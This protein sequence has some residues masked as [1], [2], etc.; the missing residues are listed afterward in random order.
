MCRT[1]K[2]QSP[3]PKMTKITDDIRFIDIAPIY[4]N[5]RFADPKSISDHYSITFMGL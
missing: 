3:K 4:S 1:P 5:G 2:I